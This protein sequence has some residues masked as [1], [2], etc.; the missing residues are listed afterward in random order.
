MPSN[1]YDISRA[2]K[3]IENDLMDSMMRNLK[4]H[5]VEENELGMTWE[6]WQ[7][8]QLQE[9]EQ[10]RIKNAKK[11]TDDF[12]DIDENIED[13]LIATFANAQAKEERDLLKKIKEKKFTPDKDKG[14]FFSL[15]EGKLNALIVA[16]KSD[17]AKG[18]FA[19]L[20]QANDQYRQIIFD[21]MTYANVTND[22]K[23][24]TKMAVKDFADNQIKQ[25]AET[26]ASQGL[27]YAQAVDK[28][29]HDYLK[30]GLRP[31]V[32]KNGARHS[33]SDYAS[34]AL[35]TG[36]KRAYLM[37]EGNAHDRYGLHTVRVNKRQGACPK[38][39]GF[40]GKLLV[41]DVYG[42]GTRAEADAQGIPTLSDAMRAGFLHPN[43][44][45][46]YSAYIPGVSQP[47]KP[48]DAKEIEQI[49][50]E[51]NLEQQIK[52]AQDTADAYSRMAKY[53][54][55]PLN[56]A[57]YEARAH[58]WQAKASELKNTLVQVSTPVAPPTTE[59]TAQGKVHNY[60]MK[61]LTNKPTGTGKHWQMA[62]NPNFNDLAEQIK[63][64]EDM[65][66]PGSEVL[67]KILYQN[68]IDKADEEAVKLKA[69]GAKLH[70]YGQIGKKKKAWQKKLDVINLNDDIA[71]LEADI[72]DI[73]AHKAT[74]LP[75]DKTYSGIWKQDVKLSEY[76]QYKAKI[77][78]K[79]DYYI[80][81]IDEWKAKGVSSY[82]LTQAEV[83]AK[84]ADLTKH[85]QDV[86][87]FETE[88][89]AYKKIAD[90][91]DT[92]IKM[93]Q[94]E[95]DL[96]KDKLDGILNP[97]KAKKSA[98]STSTITE[99]R[100]NSADFFYD[101]R[102]ADKTYRD[103]TSKAW[104]SSSRSAKDSGYY[105]TLGS[106]AH[107]RP[108]R[109]YVKGHWDA[110]DFRGVGKIPLDNEGRKNVLDLADMIE[111]SAIPEDKWFARGLQDNYNNDAIVAFFGEDRDWLLNA[112]EAELKQK[113]IGKV[114]TDEAYLS[115]GVVKSAGWSGHQFE[116]FAPQGTK[117]LYVEP[118]SHFAP[119][120]YNPLSWDGV[121]K[122]TSFGESEMLFQA[123]TDY[124][125]L[126]LSVTGTGSYRRFSVKTQ[127]VNQRSAK[128]I[129][130]IWKDRMNKIGRTI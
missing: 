42:G 37:G 84:V 78:D 70:E 106:G 69:K 26:Y 101:I 10:Y 99:A 39:V 47:A 77:N 11:F 28:A 57:K 102:E 8:L 122:Q 65:Q 68:A 114:I 17:F 94:D 100:R 13:M 79:I 33:M 9:L 18:E 55:D 127:V 15:N 61:G 29:T 88:G 90:Q 12:T 3:R 117:A 109:G 72:L 129:R 123:M 75:A 87:N 124:E 81:K 14:G 7:V 46:M 51:Y 1:E 74:A 103:I 126:D 35:R 89:H 60:T 23:K 97:K 76:P 64:I 93:K 118:F 43:C 111:K 16:T 82:G 44:K 22:Y 25:D 32:Y 34:M 27:T 6:Q 45:D 5:Q 21:A 110:S 119:H 71:K 62:L 107:N 95:L 48:W 116:T 4:R 40:L 96:A 98:K 2:F 24:A 59:F 67:L 38:C 105:Y 52:Y 130:D 113:L 85:M 58:E 112:P 73:E 19:L 66:V 63:D 41:D 50:D 54:L 120:P 121:T 83:D 56:V 36:N 30:N 31:I 91:F 49:T 20:R 86:I 104:L 125:V 128:E 92:A 115:H 108:L 80:D 53:S